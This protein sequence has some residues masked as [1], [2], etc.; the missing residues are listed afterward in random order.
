MVLTDRFD[1]Q[2]LQCKFHNLIFSSFMSSVFCLLQSWHWTYYEIYFLKRFS[3]LFE[4]NSVLITKP[5]LPMAPDVP[6]RSS[7]KKFITCSGCRSSCLHREIKLIIAVF[8]DPILSTFGGFSIILVFSARSGLFLVSVSIILFNNS[9]Y[10]SSFLFRI[11]TSLFS[12]SLAL[13]F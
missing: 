10:L 4:F 6:P 13:S 2:L 3:T 8:L 11:S 1:L 5:L 9:L 7:R 12:Y